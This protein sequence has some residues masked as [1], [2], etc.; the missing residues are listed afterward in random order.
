MTAVEDKTAKGVSVTT[1]DVASIL[2]E[3]PVTIIQ[4]S[5]GWIPLD[6]RDLWE[7]RELLYFLTWRD[8][9]V[10]YKQSLLGAAWAIIQ[11]VT[12]MIIFSVI[13]GRLAGLPSDGVPYP[14]FAYTALLPWNLFA[15]ALTRSTTSVVGSANLVQKVYF[16][17]L[18]I[19]VASTLAVLVDFAI[20][21]VILVG[22]LLYYGFAPSLATLMLPV[23]T[24]LALTVALGVGLWLS[25]LNAQYRDVGHAIPFV[26]QAWMYAS[27]VAYAA[28]LIPAQWQTL[29]ALNPMVGVIEGFRWALLRTETAPGPMVLVSAAVAVALLVSG[30]FYFRRM[31][32]TFADVV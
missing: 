13:F 16:P 31:E 3:L 8:I 21:S 27:P 10:R 2:A 22:L 28:S 5:R 12:T 32:D 26:V 7:Y 1:A 25:A 15:G 20:A 19:P 6:L 23:F 29:Y 11:P 18:V 24:L 9:K 17:R 30:A 14:V 4:P